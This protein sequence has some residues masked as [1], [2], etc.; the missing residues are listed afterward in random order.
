M[1][2]ELSIGEED[3]GTSN[4]IK[5]EVEKD[6]M[7]SLKEEYIWRNRRE[8]MNNALVAP[9]IATRQQ[10]ETLYAVASSLA[11]VIE[12][13]DVE[14]FI[15]AIERLPAQ[16]DPSAALNFQG[17]PRG[18]LLHVAAGT[19][20]DDILRLLVDYVS[21]HLIAA[22]NN[23]GDTP[24]HVAAKAWG[25]GAAAKLI[26]RARDLPNMEDTNLIL[27]KR[28]KHGNTALHEAV[29]NSHADMVR[30]LLGENPEL[31]YLNNAA[32]KSPLYLATDIENPTIH[33]VLFTPSLEPSKIEG[34]PP[35]HGA[36]GR[37]NYGLVKKILEKNM[38][39][40][41]MT[42]S[43]GGNVF[44]L[45][46][47][48]DRRPV[49]D[50]LRPETEYLAREPDMN[51]DLPIHI[52][53][54][55]G[56]VE[57]IK[58]LHPVSHLVNERGQTIL[59][60]AAKYGRDSV[61]RY[62]LRHPDLGKLINEGDQDGNTALHLAAKYSQPVTL[63]PLMLDRRIKPSLLNH[64][65][66][67]AFQIAKVRLR[68]NPMLREFLAIMVLL[69]A[70]DKSLDSVVLRPEA[71]DKLA[72]I[73]VSHKEIQQVTD[74]TRDVINARLVVAALVATVT[75]AAGLQVPGGFRGS[76]TAS[77]DDRGMATM[78][79]KGL[80]Q[81][82]A[83]CNT[84]A[85]FCSMITAIVLMYA[86]QKDFGIAYAG[87]VYASELLRVALLAMSAAFLTG[88]TLTVGKLPW[89][90]QVIF[91]LGLIFLL[92]ISV[93]ALPR[94]M[95]FALLRSHRRPILR[96]RFWLV[97]SYL[98]LFWVPKYIL[99]DPEE[100]GTASGTSASRPPDGAGESKTDDSATAKCGDAPHP[101]NH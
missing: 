91:Y 98:S 23:W 16:T 22:Q 54:K 1:D 3:V 100:D 67:T 71:R 6:E 28:N 37:H 50:L 92:I 31:V 19:G 101:P 96:L 47:Y 93:A 85:M 69:S 52:A 21:D 8:R 62:I 10:P 39:V 38:K 84:T 20:K 55:T 97:L 90:A 26:H 49:F 24:L 4:P 33:E 13:A 63:I 25:S 46:A 11:D 95:P 32:Q 70:S 45:A 94:F 44:H 9:R 57:L 82:F 78:L 58:K 75:F 59:H 48:Y 5:E 34:L 88:V 35:V 60:I 18:S 17:L 43:G 81:A 53:S 27:R 80:F 42:D 41:A 83:I 77:K 68:R 61:V 73:A 36:V 56:H 14:E 99:D 64:E 30:L 40:F 15:S 12:G 74:V 51:G 87:I 76:D 86:Q 2:V 79:D 7:D 72:L 65:S 29:L 66:S 89:L